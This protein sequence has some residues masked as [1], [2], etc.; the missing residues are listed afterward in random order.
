MT[1][2]GWGMMKLEIESDKVDEPQRVPRQETEY[3]YQLENMRTLLL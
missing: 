2:W 1:T 3:V